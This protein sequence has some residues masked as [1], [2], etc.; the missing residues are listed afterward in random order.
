[1]QE[2]SLI[3]AFFAGVISCF[4]P[5]VLPLIPPYISYITN[6]SIEEINTGNTKNKVR[7]KVALNS[8][9]F[10]LGFSIVFIIL[11]ASAT[12]LGRFFLSRYAFLMKIA[13]IILVLFGFHVMGILNFK[14]MYMEKRFNF[15]NIKLNFFSP[16]LIGMAFAFGWTPCIGPIL[17]GILFYAGTQKTILQGITLLSIYSLGLGIPFFL[18]ALTIN[19]FLTFYTKIR[20]YFR[21]LEFLSGILLIIIGL[22]IFTDN[23]QRL[24]GY[25]NFI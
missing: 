15:Q 4:S 13:G 20:K 3:T 22:L 1:M 16:I 6:I 12:V 23:L 18:I 10:I 25:L 17:A 11:G 8:F 5:C 21:V 24:S 2:I 9:L 14:W 7:Y 19:H